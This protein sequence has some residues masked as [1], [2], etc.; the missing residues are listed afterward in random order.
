MDR[1][2]KAQACAG[3]RR[4]HLRRAAGWR[5]RGGTWNNA[6]AGGPEV[7]L[8]LMSLLSIAALTY[9]ASRLTL[10]LP[11][12]SADV[13]GLRW[14]HVASLAVVAVLTVVVKYPAGAFDSQALGLVAVAQLGWFLLDMA[15]GIT[16][17][18]SSGL[19]G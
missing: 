10:R 18:R 4:R 6:V 14:A 16:P 12:F 8:S 19:A 15:R 11:L 3:L 5:K 1:R 2:R 7:L 17:G 9:F 13:A